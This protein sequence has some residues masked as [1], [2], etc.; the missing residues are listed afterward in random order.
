M[1]RQRIY[2]EDYGWEVAVMYD[3]R[4][5]GV[6]DVRR[7]LRGMDCG[8]TP[9][10]EACKHFEDG[11]ANRGCTYT[12]LGQRRTLVCVGFTTSAA[13]FMNTVA[14]ELMHAVGHIME[15]WHMGLDSEEACYLMGSLMGKCWKVVQGLVST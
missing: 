1:R 12:N 15:S 6:Q 9:L 2:V 5:D 13:E 3:V 14:H 8:G 11:V 7:E 10:E 4:A